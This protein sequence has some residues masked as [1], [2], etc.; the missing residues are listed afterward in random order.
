MFWPLPYKKFCFARFIVNFN[1]GPGSFS[2]CL[3]IDNKVYN[4]PMR[5]NKP[6]LTGE[7]SNLLVIKK[8]SGY[9]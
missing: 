4:Y 2:F 8:F 3:R 9:I 6:R 7:F 1:M 5:S